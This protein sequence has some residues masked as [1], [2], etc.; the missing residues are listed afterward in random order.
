MRPRSLLIMTTVVAVL[1]AFIF[2]YEKDL[3]STEERVELAK[4]VLDIKSEEVLGL[5]LAWADHTVKFERSPQD[6][7][8]TQDGED[9][10]NLTAQ[11]QE[12]PESH[13]PWRLTAPFAARADDSAVDSLL[14]QIASLEKTRT[15]DDVPRADAGL[16]EP[17]VTVTLLRGGE[18]PTTLEVGAEIPVAE[19][20]LVSVAGR[21]EI[22]QVANVLYGDLTKEPGDWRD[23]KLFTSPR[24]DIEKLV[25]RSTQAAVELGKR[26]ETFWLEAPIVDRADETLINNLLAE[27][28]GLK[29]R[30]F[31]DEPTGPA[32]AF[33]LEPASAVLEVALAHE[34]EPFRL[35]LGG[36]TLDGAVYGRADG[37]LFEFETEL[38]ETIARPAD[39]WRSLAWTALQVFKIDRIEIDDGDEDG[40]LTLARDGA[41][42]KRGEDRIAYSTASDFLYAITEI[43]GEEVI[44]R[45]SAESLGHD[46]TEPLWTLRFT[47][48][49]G[50]DEEELALYPVVDGKAVATARDREAVLLIDEATV[51]DLRQKLADLKSAETLPAEDEATTDDEEAASAEG[52]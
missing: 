19:A 10:G 30:S 42:W 51:D 6:D 2:F 8:K 45:P 9:P 7:A 32:S 39:A 44:E 4:K 25:L 50:T 14:Q 28:L 21:D 26:G 37:Q 43:K 38:T 48:Q 41:D 12:A 34:T 52:P 20:M 31:I 47:T 13:G 24:G 22:Y 11:D 3:P 36:A 15:L 49:E 29:I 16:D 35:E 18:E 23:R 40:P 46:L 33:G 27:V 5:E 1:L 17:R